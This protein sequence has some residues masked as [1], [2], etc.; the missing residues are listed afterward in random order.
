[1][2]LKLF[3]N[4]EKIILEKQKFQ[5]NH[6]LVKTNKKYLK[7]T[8]SHDVLKKKCYLNNLMPMVCESLFILFSFAAPELSFEFH[9]S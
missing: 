1:M 4:R 9:F 5:I 6:F 8:F 7:S 2:N 3:K